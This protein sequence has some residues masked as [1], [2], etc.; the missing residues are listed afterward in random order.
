MSA[1]EF[2]FFILL[3]AGTLVELLDFHFVLRELRS[4]RRYRSGGQRFDLI[5]G[6]RP[7]SPAVLHS[8]RALADK[9]AGVLWTP[10]FSVGWLPG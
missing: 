9:K 3:V 5:A 10:A 2:A 4:L 8:T 1:A 7:D 6:S